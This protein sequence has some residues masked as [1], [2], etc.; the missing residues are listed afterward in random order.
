MSVSAWAKNRGILFGDSGNLDAFSR[1]RVSNPTGIFSSQGQYDFDQLLYETGA[2]GTGVAPSHSANTRMTELKTAAG[3]GTSFIQSFQYI[4][5]QPGKS[6]LIFITGVL[7]AAATGVTREIGYFDDSNGVFLRQT[8]TG[9]AWVLRSKTSGEVVETVVPQTEWNLMTLETD[10]PIYVN[11]ANYDFD[12]TKNF[13]IAIDLQFL[14]M[15]RLRVGFDLDGT[16]V[17]VHEFLNANRIAVPY[18]QTATLPIRAEITTS[19]TS[20]N[21]TMYYKCASVISE[22]GQQSD[23]GY[24]FGTPRASATAGNNSR[25]HL[26]SIRPKT[27]FN[28]IEYRGTL[29]LDH[30]EIIVTGNTPVHWELVVGAAFSGAPTYADVNTTY[31][32]FEFGTGGT[33]DNLTS[34]VVIA[35]GLIPASASAKEGVAETVNIRY[36]VTLNRA[37]QQRALGTL[38]LLVSGLG[39]TSACVGTMDFFEIR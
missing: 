5:Y 3:T 1:L 28:T 20:G 25:V 9:L 10:H 6:Q 27:T 34:G 18:M 11:I 12:P 22:G 35:S 4:A 21:S 26:M 39:A 30:V 37:G 7:G 16:V 33:F 24:H 14:A 8:S 38:S 17:Y 23:V 13:I 36:P 31:S 19:G 15:G 32:G 2:T 29:I